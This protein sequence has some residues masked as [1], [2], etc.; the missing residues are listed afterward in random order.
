[1]PKTIPTV[2][3]TPNA[4]MTDQFDTIVAIPAN[5]SIPPLSV[6]PMMMP[7]RPRPR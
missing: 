6:A 1:M 7:A 2:K 4:M 3:E 5:R